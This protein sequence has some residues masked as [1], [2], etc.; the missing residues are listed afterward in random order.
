MLNSNQA[1]TVVFDKNL[2]QKLNKRR[3]L[4]FKKS[5]ERFNGRFLSSCCEMK[6]EVYHIKTNPDQY[7]G[8]YSMKEYETWSKNM[9]NIREV[10]NGAIS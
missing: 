5:C 6:C 3:L 2:L 9:T 1:C 8:N 7:L 4:K 10:L